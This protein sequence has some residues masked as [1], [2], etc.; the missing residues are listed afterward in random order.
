MSCL[1]D[2]RKPLGSEHEATA[3]R[4]VSLKRESDKWRDG[5]TLPEATTRQTFKKNFLDVSVNAPAWDVMENKVLKFFGYF[6]EHVDET[7]EGNHRVRPCEIFYYLEDDTMQIIEPKKDNS[8]MPHGAL[9]KR[10]RFPNFSS[11]GNLFS[12]FDLKVGKTFTAYGK[13]FALTGC[14]AFTREWY[15]KA[16][17]EQPADSEAVLPAKDFILNAERS[18]E[19]KISGVRQK[20]DPKLMPETVCRFDAFI[21]DCSTNTLERR[22][23][24]I[25]YFASD[26]TV[27]IR[28]ILPS[29]GGFAR[30]SVF[31]SRRKILKGN[32]A[33]AGPSDPLPPEAAYFHLKDFQVGSVVV[34]AD[35]EFFIYAADAFTRS[36][37]KRTLGVTLQEDID[38]E[39]NPISSTPNQIIK[40]E[41]K[42]N[43]NHQKE[44]NISEDKQTEEP[45]VYNAVADADGFICTG[46]KE[47]IFVYFPQ[48]KSL[49][50]FDQNVKERGSSSFVLL[51]R[52]LYINE[53]TGLPFEPQDFAV[54]SVFT[55]RRQSFR[56]T[57][58]INE[59]NG[60]S[61]Y[62]KED[63]RR[64]LLHLKRLWEGLSGNE[65]KMSEMFANCDEQ[66]NGVLTYQDFQKGMARFGYSIS[67]QEAV[68]IAR[69]FD[70]SGDGRINFEEFCGGISELQ[71]AFIGN[72]RRLKDIFNEDLDVYRDAAKHESTK[73][74]QANG[75]TKN[76]RQ[77]QA[78]FYQKPR[79]FNLLT[80]EFSRSARGRK[81]SLEEAVQV[82]DRCG[83]AQSREAIKSTIEALMPGREV[84][85]LDY[86]DLISALK[87]ACFGV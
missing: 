76:F 44:G 59:I 23:F 73:I 67:E 34:V 55:L 18:E 63:K 49:S 81:V 69:Y 43:D 70:T 39:S 45:L 16:N 29:R 19:L 5:R 60:K 28:E 4:F 66:G 80:K 8:G 20:C 38:I 32:R 24:T 51:R 87:A 1:P 42:V 62:L 33:T 64:V 15:R 52:D 48:D 57:N 6:K 74:E 26:A 7:A 9:V 85:E 83:C 22:K 61:K 58:Q 65:L 31:I 36:F 53:A 12:P 84:Q 30:F 40:K 27:E 68:A 25:L 78:R 46:G 17:R 2:P 75:I 77:L 10:H 14:D 54:G 37:I 82:F 13:T 79:L 71:G 41:N 50:V 35:R 47:V 21:D 72:S 86:I 3:S 56:V 11:P